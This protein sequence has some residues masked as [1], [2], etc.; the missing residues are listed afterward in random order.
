[1]KGAAK[2]FNVIT[3]IFIIILVFWFTQL[4]YEDLSFKENRNV[5]FGMLSVVLMIFAIQMIKRSIV[6]NHQK[7]QGNDGAKGANKH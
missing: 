3:I 1:M 4:N 6:K 2:V 5:Y 7:K